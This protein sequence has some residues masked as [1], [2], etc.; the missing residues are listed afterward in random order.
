M[1]TV[2]GR[3]ESRA[4]ELEHKSGDWFWLKAQS[5]GLWSYLKMIVIVLLLLVAGAIGAEILWFLAEPRVPMGQRNR[6][7]S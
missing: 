6:N 1:K 7:T 5:S 4:A 3:E 2:L